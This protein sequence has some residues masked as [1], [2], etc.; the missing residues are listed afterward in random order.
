MRPIAFVA[1]RRT[2]GDA[3][4]S[5]AAASALRQRILAVD[6]SAVSQHLND[7]GYAILPPLLSPSQCKSLEKLYDRSDNPDTFRSTINMS[8]YNFGQGEYRYFAYPLPEI[9]DTL[10]QDLYVPMAKIANEWAQH[11]GNPE[12][13]SKSLDSFIEYCRVHGQH[14]PT[15]L[16]LR[17]KPGDYNCLHQDL[18]G[19]IYFP[20]QVVFMLSKPGEDFAG[21]EL[22]LVEQRPR[23]QSRAMVLNLAQGGAA[24]IPVRERPR[25]GK[26]GFHRVQ[27]RHGVSVVSHGQRTTLGIIFHDAR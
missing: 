2:R 27:M 9:V 20:L 12:R 3:M 18:Y 24:V 22:V 5:A 4:M 21:G 23:M 25:Q 11:L 8:R 17:Y 10:R 7:Q 1:E 13:W 14:R 15:P 16:L 6:W 26:R 19:D